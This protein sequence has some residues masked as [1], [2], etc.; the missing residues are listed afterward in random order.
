MTEIS[1]YLKPD[2]SIIKTLYPK[3]VIPLRIEDWVKMPFFIIFC[4]LFAVILKYNLSD[5]V[6]FRQLYD[7]IILP[8]IIIFGLSMTVGKLF[9]RRL[10]V[11]N[12]IYYITNQ[13]V[14]IY[15]ISSAR[16]IKSFYFDNFPEMEC[17]ENLNGFG[18][19]ILGEKASLGVSNGWGTAGINMLEH[20]FVLNNITNV[21]AEYDFIKKMILNKES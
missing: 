19:I 13:R 11:V 4:F 18:Y 10:G 7:Y 9:F 3:K 2:E 20:K 6:Q 1:T 15:N 12:S 8:L 17:R 5:S 21:K 14:I 16:T